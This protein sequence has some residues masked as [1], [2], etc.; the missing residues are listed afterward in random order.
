[1]LK[2]PRSVLKG[3]IA[4]VSVL[5]G[6]ALASLIAM[7]ILKNKSC[8][9]VACLNGTCQPDGT[10][11][12]SS[13]RVTGAACDTVLDKCHN[14]DCGSHGTCSTTDGACVCN[15][16][17]TGP[18]CSQQI[19]LTVPTQGINGVNGF[20][21]G[22][23]DVFPFYKNVFN[24]TKADCETMCVTDPDCLGFNINES[25]KVGQLFRAT[26]ADGYSA[27]APGWKATTAFP[28]YASPYNCPSIASPKNA[29]G[30]VSS[31]AFPD[32]NCTRELGWECYSNP[33]AT[34]M[35]V[36]GRRLAAEPTVGCRVIVSNPYL[37]SS[38]L[39]TTEG[40][41][42]C[43]FFNM[44]RDARAG[45]TVYLCNAYL[46]L[47]K[48]QSEDPADYQS[49]I[50]YALLAALRRNVTVVCV[51]VTTQQQ[52][53][54]IDVATQA[55]LVDYLTSG[56]LRY[57]DIYPTAYAF[58]HDKI[59]LSDKTAYVGGQNMSGS[60]SV[61]VGVEITAAS[62]LYADL[63]QRVLYLANQ[64]SGPLSLKY[65]ATSPW[66]D[67]DNTN[68]FVAV[69]PYVPLQTNQQGTTNCNFPQARLSPP[70]S[71]VGPF[72]VQ[73]NSSK[74]LQANAGNVSY[75]YTHLYNLIENAKTFLVITNYDWSI[76]G[77]WFS[78]Y[79]KPGADWN[80]AGALQRAVERGV[81]VDV[82]ISAMPFSDS[83]TPCGN[84]TCQGLR[85]SDFSAWLTG[86]QSHSN[87]KMHWWYQSPAGDSFNNA[88]H[89]LHA[90]IY[91]SDW[92]ALISSSNFTPQYFAATQSVGF[93]AVFGTT[94]T[95]PSWVSDGINA[96]ITI[97]KT[98]SKSG[99]YTCDN[100]STPNFQRTSDTGKQLCTA[101]G[102]S[103]T[104]TCAGSAGMWQN[105]TR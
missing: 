68:Y 78:A 53:C 30:C 101:D 18:Q 88:C 21:K 94:G 104:N 86:L 84:T 93:C 10:C 66:K 9:T 80:M 43:W 47:F 81:N 35:R 49:Q 73:N 63:K 91:Y 32:N 12:C 44:L 65:T 64:G 75:E 83:S 71:G 3:S 74:Q 79:A 77:D 55:S 61:D 59:Y 26:A 24:V 19:R 56:Q 100:G 15:T 31:Y 89:V 48:H 20:C 27:A 13:A 96:V 25:T 45:S 92:G 28:T 5:L 40:T 90:K 57:V 105:C 6:G 1:M 16:G 14:V 85:C 33:H 41:F 69:S 38:E 29:G 99:K 2:K 67:T 50:F 36:A 82:W 95:G 46:T 39:L 42:Y 70:P 60:S 8:D 62:P 34:K 7:I 23:H 17:Y 37:Y 52:Q 76:F 11:E 97:L 54:Q 98:K 22:S 51:N 102:T 87:F 58:F 72:L 4:L 103:C